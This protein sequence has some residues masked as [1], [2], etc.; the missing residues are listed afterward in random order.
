MGPIHPSDISPFYGLLD[1]YDLLYGWA[2][3]ILVIF[4]NSGLIRENSPEGA[5]YFSDG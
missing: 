1:T 2:A 5:Q 3:S 4:R